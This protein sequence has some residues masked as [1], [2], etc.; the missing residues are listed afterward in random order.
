MP[1]EEIVNISK[2]AVPETVLLLLVSA[3]EDRAEQVISLL[4][5]HHIVQHLVAIQPKEIPDRKVGASTEY[6]VFVLE[7]SLEEALLLV[8]LLLSTVDEQDEGEAWRCR[9]RL[10]KCSFLDFFL[11]INVDLLHQVIFPE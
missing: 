10:A 11:L 8:V 4:P 7:T 5:L 1:L 2:S 3:V 9:D 6:P